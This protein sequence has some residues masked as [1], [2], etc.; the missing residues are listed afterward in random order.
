[1]ERI[2]AAALGHRPVFA[3][4]RR[5]RSALG[6]WIT[7]T[8]L[9]VVVAGAATVDAKLGFAVAIAFGGAIVILQNPSLIAP[10][11]FVTVCVEGVVV[12]NVAV[13]RILAPCALLLVL[14]ELIRGAA[15]IRVSG[16]FLW[17]CGYVTWA[18]ASTLWTTS[19]AGTRFLLQSLLIAVVFMLIYAALINTEEQLRRVVYTIGITSGIVGA[20]SVIA[21]GLSIPSIVGLDLLQSGRSQGL[22]DDPD[23][24]AAMQLVAVPLVIVLATEARTHRIR[25]LMYGTLIMILAS[26]F[27]SLSRG[28][29]LAIAVLAILLV[30]TK[31]ERL[32]Q[33]RR[34]KALTLLLA[35]L[36]MTL[37][38][39]RPY[40]RGE[41]VQRAESIY[42]PKDR[43]EASGA[44]RTNLW[45]AAQKITG[46]NLL[47]G[48]GYGS[49]T[50]VSEDLLL[51]TPGV[52]PLLLQNRGEGDNFVAHNT[53]LGT[54][55]E[56]GIPGLTL[57]LGMIFASAASLRR[58]SKRARAAGAHFLGRI[59]HALFLGLCSWAVTSVFLSGETA[60]ML[61]ILVGLSLAL[62]KLA[63]RRVAEAREAGTLSPL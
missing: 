14:A 24:F 26:A 6:W 60:R 31:P 4:R 20:L 19:L 15:R 55:A 45:K 27:T 8:F 61:W 48:I 38:F 42:A 11:G 50:Y 44:G 29:F 62:A 37:F 58:T 23:F 13:T 18:F 35:T 41:V 16:P 53:Y 56:L 2:G 63:D 30:S 39:S 46:E 43:D 54:S 34:Q 12:N 57:L 40:V 33:S 1:M 17:A 28:A 32:F 36:G 59:S 47:T 22:V 51:R 9:A 3:V 21:F 5:F 52:D 25:L 7:A 49:F 10:V